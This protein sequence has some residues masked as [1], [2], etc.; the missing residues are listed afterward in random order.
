MKLFYLKLKFLGKIYI[1]QLIEFK[2][3]LT[4]M[5]HNVLAEI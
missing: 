5:Y 4:H 3:Y 1:V 2:T